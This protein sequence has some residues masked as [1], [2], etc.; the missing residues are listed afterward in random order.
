MLMSGNRRHRHPS[1]GVETMKPTKLLG[2]LGT[3]FIAPAALAAST[4]TV[5]QFRD[6]AA[7]TAQADSISAY[8]IGTSSGSTLTGACLHDYSPGGWGIVNSAEISPCTGEP[9]TGPHAADNAAGTDMFLLK[10]NTAV[11][12]THV[13]IGWNGTDDY[14]ADSDISVLAYGGSVT[15][16]VSGKNLGTTSA[17]LLGSNWSVVA[18]I[19]DVGAK[20]GN[21][22]ATG[23]TTYSSWW[24]VSAWNSAFGG[25]FCDHVT[26]TACGSSYIDYFKLVSVTVEPSTSKVPEPGSLAL[27]GVGLL[28]LLRA[29]RKNKQ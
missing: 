1:S 7:G 5:E 23:A 9:G 10:F 6:S 28:G 24:I 25:G 2:L 16:T 12:L 17:G 15:P 19:S 29:R 27:L 13:T 4:W 3:M 8:Y 14:A 18:N 21:T 22:G 20:A 26:S 11:K